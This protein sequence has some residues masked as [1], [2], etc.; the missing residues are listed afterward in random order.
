MIRDPLV[1]RIERAC[2]A[3]YPPA[4]RAQVGDW[5]VSLSGGGS[6]RSNSASAVRPDAILDAATLR[7]LGDAFASAEQAMILRIT[8][9][10]GSAGDLLDAAGFSA[11]EGVTRTLVCP[12]ASVGPPSKAPRP[13]RMETTLRDTPDARWLVTRRRL[14][15]TVE[16]PW[17]V[18]ARLAAPA[19]YA[20]RGDVA[21]GYA[22]LH[23]SIAVIEAIGT[24]RAARRQGHARAIVAALVEWAVDAGAEHVALQI[25]E[26]NA[27]ARALYDRAGFV[28]D[29]YGYHYRRNP[30]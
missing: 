25:E 8:E 11:P 17:Q 20:R 13:D 18:A 12:V 15:P 22:A 10:T 19:C 4:R 7:A 24:D 3:A 5:A 27:A 6:R 28:I 23:D 26:T 9:L 21:I 29:A 14:A 30:I 16:D 1:W 2:I